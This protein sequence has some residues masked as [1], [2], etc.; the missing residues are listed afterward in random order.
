[1]EGKKKEMG[2]A[3]EE[4]QTGEED[5]KKTEQ[6]DMSVGVEE[7]TGGR[8]GGR[9]QFRPENGPEQTALCSIVFLIY[10]YQEGVQTK[11]IS[12]FLACLRSHPIYSS[13]DE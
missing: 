10:D 8:R 13:N 11:S 6:K 3:K 2:A 9:G 12:H 4:D 1:M 7:E 5:R